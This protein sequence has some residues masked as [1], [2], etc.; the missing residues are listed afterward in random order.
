MA[1][2]RAMGPRGAL[3]DL[4]VGRCPQRRQCTSKDDV[5]HKLG[6]AANVLRM[7]SRHAVAR[8]MDHGGTEREFEPGEIFMEQVP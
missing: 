7:A 1:K 2:T 6:A 3:M 5:S 8:R 4:Q